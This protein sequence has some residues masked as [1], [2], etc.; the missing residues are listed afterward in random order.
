MI[1][2]DN[3]ATSF[4]KP[5]CVIDAANDCI[6]NWCANSGRSSHKN[7][8]VTNE[9]I[10]SAREIVSDFLSISAPEKIVFTLNATY[11]LNIAIKTLIPEGKHV[12]ISDVEHNSVLRPIEMMKKTANCEYSVFKSGEGFE[13]SIN[14]LIRKNT[15]AIVSTLQSNVT[16][17]II[18]YKTLYEIADKYGLILILDASQLIG[19]K[20]IDLSDCPPD[21]IC[22][23]AHKGLLGIQG[24]GFAAF[25]K[26][27]PKKSFIEGGSGNLSML[28]AMP[29][30][31]PEHFEAG[32]LPAPAIAALEA[33][34]GYINGIGIDNIEKK[35]DRLTAY[36]YEGLSEIKGF[37]I[38][39]RSHGI[40]SFRH[41]SR[42]IDN[43][44][45]ENNI[46]TRGGL[47]CAPMAH[48]KLGTVNSGLTRVSFS[49]FNTEG[50]IDF[51]LELLKKNYI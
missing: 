2:L 5:K 18:S 6:S 22:A 27:T 41:K 3:A 42:V 39:G 13:R 48:K 24:L 1:Y 51:L 47:H 49:Y 31:L 19:H 7:A 26:E 23:P 10:F 40:V 28:T 11:A 9:K 16:G 43:L 15:A 46:A 34:I 45:N 25:C 35:I 32:T 20:R 17:E 4:P 50:E 29:D 8:L 14:A 44:L 33:G 12:I 21:A 30:M 37:E 36:F 38:F